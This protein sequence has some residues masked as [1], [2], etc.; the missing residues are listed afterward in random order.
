MTQNCGNSSN[1]QQSAPIHD[2][3]SFFKPTNSLSKLPKMFTFVDQISLCS[4]P[5]LIFSTES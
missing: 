5:V 1:R 4:R 2:E 3:K